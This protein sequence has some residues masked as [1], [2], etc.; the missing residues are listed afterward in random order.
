MVGKAKTVL[1][2]ESAELA[3]ALAGKIIQEELDEAK[4]RKLIDQFI[5]EFNPH[6]Y[7]KS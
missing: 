4:H 3:V 7:Q 5:K 6:V 1:Q 2:E